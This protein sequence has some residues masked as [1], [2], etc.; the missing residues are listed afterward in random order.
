MQGDFNV[1]IGSDA[2]EEWAE[3]AGRFGIRNDRGQRLLEFAGKHR[4]V[5]ANTLFHIK[6]QGVPH[7]TLLMVKYTTK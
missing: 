3:C 7:G 2:N 5:A 1:N 6:S 4:L